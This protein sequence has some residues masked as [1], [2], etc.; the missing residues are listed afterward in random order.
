MS[1]KKSSSRTKDAEKKSKSKE[2]A[3]GKSSSK[4]KERASKSSLASKD[5]ASADT[6]NTSPTG[7][8]GADNAGTTSPDFEAG[9]LFGRYASAGGGVDARDFQRLWRDYRDR[10]SKGTG[11]APLVEPESANLSPDLVA[12]LDYVSARRGLDERLSLAELKA[13]FVHA[14]EGERRLGSGGAPAAVV[15]PTAPA[16]AIQ[17]GSGGAGA[18]G[19]GAV[20][21]K[22]LGNDGEQ[23]R[24]GSYDYSNVSVGPPMTHYSETTGVPLPRAA[25]AGELGLGHTVVPLH[26]AYNRRLGRLQALMSSRLMPAREQLLQQ[27]RRLLSRAEEVS[28]YLPGICT[29]VLCSDMVWAGSQIKSAKASIER[30]TMADTNAVLERLRSADALKQATI[31]QYIGGVTAELDAVDKIVDQVRPLLEPIGDLKLT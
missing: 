14:M 31:S 26:E 9:L 13:E 1:E 3:H 4:S 23:R 5:A 7:E 21:G 27:R 24:P 18:P 16:S 22:S 15:S 2:K 12:L 30:E 8:V 10:A 28:S 20:G 17:S 29:R 11:P 25:V 19:A 6:L